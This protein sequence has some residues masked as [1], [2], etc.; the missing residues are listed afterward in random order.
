MKPEIKKRWVEALR[1][2]KYEQGQGYLNKDGK[3]CCLGVLCEVVKDEIGLSNVLDTD[4]IT[5][6]YGNYKTAVLPS[7][8]E[9]YCGIESFQDITYYNNIASL[10]ELNDNKGLTF[11]EIADIIEE[12]L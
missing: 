8:V 12:Q 9:E 5:M 2:N 1:S 11:D 6:I 3:Y 10:E 7:E 4:G